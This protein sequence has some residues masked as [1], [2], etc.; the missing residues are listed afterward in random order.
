MYLQAAKF[1]VYDKH[2]LLYINHWQYGQAYFY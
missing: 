2:N 1:N